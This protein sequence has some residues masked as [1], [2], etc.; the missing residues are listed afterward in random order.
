MT[1]TKIS[2]LKVGDK[3]V[4]TYAV[5]SKSLQAFKNKSGQFLSLMLGDASGEIRGVMWDGAE[6]AA[7]LFKT[8]DAITVRTKVE[9]YRGEKQF[10]IDKL[11]RASEEE[12]DGADL[13][14]KT[15][16]DPEELRASLM[17]FVEEVSDPHL[18]ALLDVIFGD[19]DFVDRFCRAP[20]AKGLHHA[21]V[22]GL[23]EHTVG[24]ARVLSTVVEVHP[25]LNRDL[26]IAGA[27]LHDLGK[28]EELETAIAIDYTDKGRLV[29]HIV[30]TDRMVTRA[31]DQIEGFP[32]ELADR[33]AHLLLSHHGQK[34]YGAPVQP[35]T[36]EACAL[37]YA[38]NL[39]A[40]VQYFGRVIADGKASGNHWSDYQR[41]F[42][43][44][45]YIGGQCE[46]EGE[47]DTAE[48][49]EASDGDTVD[50][51]EGDS[52]DAPRLL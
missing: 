6:A 30:I 5:K 13:L 23:V 51:G 41:L 31:I 4:G 19:E 38:D 20:G 7:E 12:C 25:A 37:H 49:D 33:L 17:A 2:D 28:I 15:D 26:L 22:S 47:T 18:S 46:P 40:H 48:D 27:L 29:G 42:D 8:G 16:R 9:E 43:R 52:E 11:K 21:H 50:C 32:A 10:V 34:E 39:D 35:M 45:I 36:A 24:V 3:I 1:S 14:A 44:Y